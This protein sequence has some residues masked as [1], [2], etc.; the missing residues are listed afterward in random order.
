MWIFIIYEI[1]I[2][3][4]SRVS[5]RLS[6]DEAKKLLARFSSG[7]EESSDSAS[8]SDGETF[9]N[10]S[11]GG[12]DKNNNSS[13]AAISSKQREMRRALNEAKATSPGG[14]KEIATVQEF[15]KPE[16]QL[17]FELLRFIVLF[18]WSLYPTGYVFGV[19]DRENSV[20]VLN[21]VYNIADLI[22]KVAF[23]GCI[24]YA[25]CSQNEIE[26]QL[27]LGSR[28]PTVKQLVARRGGT[29]DLVSRGLREKLRLAAISMSGTQTGG[30]NNSGARTPT[31]MMN[32]PQGM[33]APASAFGGPTL[34]QTTT[35]ISSQS[36]PPGKQQQMQQTPPGGVP[37][38]ALGHST[39]SPQGL[40]QSV[41]Q[42]GILRQST[43][44]QP[45]QQSVQQPQFGS[46]VPGS[47]GGNFMQ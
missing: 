7:D 8:D 27:I 11:I 10:K 18:G 43:P 38:S 40:P 14:N 23:G 34:L 16:A 45:Q 12:V 29:L 1:F 22:N 24:Y 32:F 30:S 46:V 31:N 33:S 6:L 42:P 35:A 44:Q 47:Q 39:M 36:M 3:E 25:A 13:Q 4:A 17:A 37:M 9:E 5:G 2:G 19:V 41:S 26:K 28:V 21:A 15:K 20:N